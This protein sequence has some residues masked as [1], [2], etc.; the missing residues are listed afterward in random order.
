MDQL[1]QTL[2]DLRQIEFQQKNGSDEGLLRPLDKALRSNQLRKAFVFA[3]MMHGRGYCG[4]TIEINFLAQWV[5]G[6]SLRD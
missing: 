3:G 6:L 2:D 1:V 5:I 4:A